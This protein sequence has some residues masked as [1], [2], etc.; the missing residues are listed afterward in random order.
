MYAGNA[1]AKVQAKDAVKVLSIRPTSF[2][3]APMEDTGDVEASDAA[4][5]EKSEW[6]GESVQETDRPDLGSASVVVSGGRGLQSGEN[7]GMLEQVADALG[8]G[9]EDDTLEA[10]PA[11]TKERR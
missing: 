9:A 3:K 8:G 2:D 11:R 1:S 4:E 10:M 7:F 5:F 6:V